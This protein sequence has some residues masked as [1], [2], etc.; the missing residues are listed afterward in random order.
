MYHGQGLIP[1]KAPAFDRAVNI[2]LGLPIIRTSVE[3]GTAPDIAWTGQAD[4]TSMGQAVRLAAEL[5]T[6]RPRPADNTRSSKQWAS[7]I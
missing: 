7:A 1:L 3:H 2:T 4:V 5:A 6:G